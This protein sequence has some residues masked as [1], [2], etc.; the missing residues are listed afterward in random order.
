MV[1]S[2]G[3]HYSE[4]AMREAIHKSLKGIA[5]DTTAR[6]PRIQVLCEGLVG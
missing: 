4:G 6:S 5:F 2:L 3:K 1:L